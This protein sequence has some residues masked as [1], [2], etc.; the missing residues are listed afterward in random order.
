MNKKIFIRLS[1]ILGGILFFLAGII[2]GPYF[3]KLSFSLSLRSRLLFGLVTFGFYLLLIL[4]IFAVIRV[5]KDWHLVRFG[6]R[7]EA[8]LLLSFSMVALITVLPI[9]FVL[10]DLFRRTWEI[11]SIPSISEGI[12]EAYEWVKSEDEKKRTVLRN[13]ASFLQSN[14]FSQTAWDSL[15]SKPDIDLIVLMNKKGVYNSFFR[16]KNLSFLIKPSDLQEFVL[17]KEFFVN[18]KG[19][20]KNYLIGY[21]NL[22]SSK[23]MILALGLGIPQKEFLRNIKIEKTWFLYNQREFLKEPLYRLFWLSLVVFFLLMILVSFILS[24]ALSRQIARPVFLLSEGMRQVASGNYNFYLEETGSKDVKVLFKIFNNMIKELSFNQQAILH[25]RHIEAWKKATSLRLEEANSYLKTLKIL[26]E[27]IDSE[28][29]KKIF[30]DLEKSLVSIETLSSGNTLVLRKE[31][32]NDIVREV[33][34]MFRNIV[35]DVS[36][37]LE[38]DPSIPL[39]NINRAQIEQAIVNLV[40]N[41]VEANSKTVEIKTTL[42]NRM[43][44][45]IVRLEIS[46]DGCG[47]PENIE[48]NI[49]EPFVTTKKNKQGLGLTVTKRIV[50]EHN[51]RISF[52]RREGKT[53]FFIEWNM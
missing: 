35:Q 15:T 45:V 18:K 16:V 9:F 36:F 5:I 48:K 50:E 47:I 44:G 25:S 3:F 30:N 8:R 4:L 51:G 33:I 2:F 46:D 43:A 1:I 6:S 39:M 11:W 10:S 32:L 7:F 31:D 17:D 49:F 21:F 23:D 28:D 19:P 34:D 40:K 53:V 26:V 37:Y 42:L 14:N 24:I 38:L 13:M 12:K 20:D 41:A 29:I 27:K 52:K 22:N